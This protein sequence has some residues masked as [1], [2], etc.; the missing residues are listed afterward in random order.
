MKLD[1]IFNLANKKR[2]LLICVEDELHKCHKNDWVKIYV[3]EG[4]GEVIAIEPSPAVSSQPGVGWTNFPI[5]LANRKT[6]DVTLKGLSAA[7]RPPDSK[8]KKKKN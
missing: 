4:R 8:K 7:R 6:Y 1:K 3:D 2:V 5:N